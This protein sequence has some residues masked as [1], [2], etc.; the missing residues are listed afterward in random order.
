MRLGADGRG[1]VDGDKESIFGRRISD[2]FSLTQPAPRSRKDARTEVSLSIKRCSQAGK[3]KV[4]N[5][6]IDSPALL[7]LRNQA[8]RVVPYACEGRERVLTNRIIRA[9][10]MAGFFL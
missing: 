10:V 1:T 8:R 4:M 6:V 2:T 7:R 9:V 5:R 3:E